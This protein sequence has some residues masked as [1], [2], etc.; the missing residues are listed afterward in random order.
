MIG[1]EYGETYQDLAKLVWCSGASLTRVH[2]PVYLKALN[3]RNARGKHLLTSTQHCMDLLPVELVEEILTK[4]SKHTLARVARTSK[5]YCTLS[6]KLLYANIRLHTAG[7]TR[8]LTLRSCLRTLSSRIQK[9][10]YVKFFDLY[11]FGALKEL[12]LDYLR[13]ALA[14]MKNL[15][16]L[17]VDVE[18]FHVMAVADVI[19][20]A[21]R[22]ST[23]SLTALRIPSMIECD[24]WI[25]SQQDLKAVVI[26]Y[27]DWTWE[28]E[29]KDLNRLRSWVTHSMS[30]G[31]NISF[32][33]SRS[34]W[35]SDL[36]AF[37]V[38]L[39]SLYTGGTQKT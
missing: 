1:R 2:C 13:S 36:I 4:C 28:P 38:S 15:K 23:F 5:V 10:A 24:A 31:K 20:T 16:H 35:P 34:G 27:H 21:L 14:G 25:A 22:R 8:M 26:F 37:Q 17:S 11:I 19:A 32:V 3:A 18:S 29:A 33:K 6:E 7:D 39:R 9:A 12:E 30:P